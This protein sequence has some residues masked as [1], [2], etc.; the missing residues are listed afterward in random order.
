MSFPPMPPAGSARLALSTRIRRST[1]YSLTARGRKYQDELPGSR[2]LGPAPVSYAEFKT[3]THDAARP[4]AVTVAKLSTALG[5]K[6]TR[7]MH[8][9][10]IQQLFRSPAGYLGPVGLAAFHA[11]IGGSQ[12]QRILLEALP[13]I[14]AELKA[15]GFRR[16]CLIAS[17]TLSSTRSS[18]LASAV[19]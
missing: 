13:I 15:R 3:A 17:S 6:E 4:T 2:Y 19:L 5:G 7:P 12:T 1:R 11:D 18:P 9:E 16:A 8:P 14:L 10:E